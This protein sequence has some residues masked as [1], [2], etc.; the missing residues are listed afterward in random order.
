MRW[1]PRRRGKGQQNTP[2]RRIA[3]RA[4]QVRRRPLR[5]LRWVALLAVL[6]GALVFL[7]GYSRAFVVHD[8]VVEGTEG[9]LATAVVDSA[10][11][12]TGRPLARVD[13]GDVREQILA[14][15]RVADVEVKR[16]WPDAI[17]L[18]VSPR[19]PVLAVRSGSSGD[20]QA[21]DR[22]GVLF[23]PVGGPAE[24]LPKLRVPEAG[25]PE[26]Q[27][28]GVAGLLEALPE[29]LRSRVSD[30]RL[31]SS[32]TVQFTIGTMKVTWGDVSQSELKTRVLT[33][34][35]EQKSI[36]PDNEVQPVTV[37][38]SAPETPV[39]TGMPIAPPED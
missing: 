29:D 30:L 38:L 12:P 18:V 16:S 28:A 20:Y 21:A 2:H 36:D 6:V 8:V 7:F 35:L 5:P 33:A 31:R 3:E 10:A 25:A 37:D 4:A 34:L 17:T 11:I 39:L 13:T 22:A 27:V 14:D 19:E 26:E 32:G 15:P 9:E 23:D 24:D 1:L